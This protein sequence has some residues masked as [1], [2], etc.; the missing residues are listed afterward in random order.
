MEAMN[1]KGK[2]DRLV[3]V[4]CAV[5]AVLAVATVV[6]YLFPRQGAFV[7]PEREESAVAGAP[8]VDEALGY[9]E[10]YQDGMAYRVALCGVP[11]AEDGRLT[12]YFTNS[13]ENGKYL[14]LRVLDEGGA[15]LGET[16]LL[17]PG[18]YVKDVAL[19]APVAPGTPLRLKVMGYEPEDYTSAGALTLKVTTAE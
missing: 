1:Y 6:V 14:K 4:L 15:V 16:G 17:Y 11:V 7:P 8:Q 5:L 3:L 19:Y 2:R 10:L 18:E 13:A 9:T 12:V